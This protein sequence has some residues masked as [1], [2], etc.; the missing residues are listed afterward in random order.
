MILGIGKMR[1]R[2]SV[3]WYDVIQWVVTD[4][5]TNRF[6]WPERTAAQARI[7]GLKKVRR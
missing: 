6:V 2:D 4:A 3:F 1:V 5:R 7:V